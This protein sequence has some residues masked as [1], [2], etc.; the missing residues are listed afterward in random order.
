LFFSLSL[1]KERKNIKKFVSFR[2]TTNDEIRQKSAAT[3]NEKIYTI[4]YINNS[5]L[6]AL[7]TAY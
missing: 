6:P 5:G 4:I 1:K 2:V 3:R 7:Q